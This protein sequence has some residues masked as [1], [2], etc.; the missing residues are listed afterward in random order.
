MKRESR[1]IEVIIDPAAPRSHRLDARDERTDTGMTRNEP[2]P[3]LPDP[4]EEEEKRS[5]KNWEDKKRLNG[6]RNASVN[7]YENANANAKHKGNGRLRRLV[8]RR[9]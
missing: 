9:G 8:N 3:G 5:E 2:K 6:N 1:I 7:V 4:R